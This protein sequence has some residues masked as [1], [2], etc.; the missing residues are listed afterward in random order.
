MKSLQ[1]AQLKVKKEYEYLEDNMFSSIFDPQTL[2][3]GLVSK[4]INPNEG[5]LLSLNSIT[6]LFRKKSKPAKP[7]EVLAAKALTDTKEISSTKKPK[8]SFAKKVAVSFVKWQL[9]NLACWG[10]HKA[11]DAYTEKRK[12]EKALKALNKTATKLLKE[13][14]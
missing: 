2:G 8:K 12:K 6:S 10:I 13:L 14:D 9:F 3:M 1:E 11:Y 5:G 7:A 4:I